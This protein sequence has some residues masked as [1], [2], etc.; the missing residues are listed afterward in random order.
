[1]LII[2]IVKTKK[3][4]SNH[5]VPKSINKPCFLWVEY[6]YCSFIVRVLYEVLSYF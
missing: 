1:M 3:R 6:L 5:I 2:L 4:D